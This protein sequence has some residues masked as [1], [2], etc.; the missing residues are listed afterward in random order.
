MKYKKEIILI[1]VITI[2]SL[3]ILLLAMTI[4]LK[5]SASDEPFIDESLYPY[6]VETCEEYHLS[7]ELVCSVIWHESR[8]QNVNNG[9]CI[10]LMQISSKWHTERMQKL[11]VDDLTDEKQNILVGIDYLAELFEKYEDPYLVL[12]LYNMKRST[13]F[14]NYNNGNFS[15][16]AISVLDVSLNFEK[17]KLK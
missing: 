3:I 16:Y 9:N 11:G 15:D 17:E 10:G 7:P 4:T 5:V 6:I 2:T 14:K 13:A 12:M 1:S 8:W